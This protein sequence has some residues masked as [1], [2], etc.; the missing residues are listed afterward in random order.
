MEVGRLEAQWNPVLCMREET[1]AP[2]APRRIKRAF[3]T[4]RQRL[5]A[6]S[7]ACTERQP[8][9]LDELAD[10]GHDGHIARLQ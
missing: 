1:E 8:V 6:L 10:V 2:V 4:V 3:K 9:A 7:G 5:P